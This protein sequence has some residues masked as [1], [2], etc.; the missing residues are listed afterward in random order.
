MISRFD[1]SSNPVFLERSTEIRN[2]SKRLFEMTRELGEYK[3]GE[4]IKR[5]ES[6]LD[7]LPENIDLSGVLVSMDWNLESL[8]IAQDLLKICYQND[9]KICDIKL[10][11]SLPNEFLYQRQNCPYEFME[12]ALRKWDRLNLNLNYYPMLK[13][14]KNLCMYEPGSI[15]NVY[16]KEKIDML[17]ISVTNKAEKIK[18]LCQDLGN[19]LKL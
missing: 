1:L 7:V 14:F 6:V 16:L 5:N 15:E 4:I 10:I 17:Q 18:E 19:D 2:E 3:L 8:E 11:D 12:P 13:L 9:L